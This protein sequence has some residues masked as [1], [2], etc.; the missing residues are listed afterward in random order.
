[1]PINN[2]EPN[3]GDSQARKVIHQARVEVHLARGEYNSAVMRNPNPS[4]D[5]VLNLAQAAEQYRG[6]LREYRDEN[7]LSPP[8][9]E[10]NLDWIADYIGETV[11]VEVKAPGMTSNTKTEQRPAILT[12][13]PERIKRLTHRLDDVRKELGFAARPSMSEAGVRD[14]PVDP[15]GERRDE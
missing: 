14:N 15:R 4:P 8:W 10:R 3:R 5:V 1:M 7:V 12:V 11:S 9:D 2:D 6:T 13:N